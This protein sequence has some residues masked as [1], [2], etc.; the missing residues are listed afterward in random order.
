MGRAP[1]K[2]TRLE[3]EV[4]IFHETEILSERPAST[5]PLAIRQAA[6]ERAPAQ[7]DAKSKLIAEYLS[8]FQLV[9]KGGLYIDGFAA[10]QKR[11]RLDSWTARRVLEITLNRPGFTG[12]PNPPRIANHG[13][14]DHQEAVLARVS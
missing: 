9:T 12:G 1:R 8:R 2:T 10:P 3:G 7:T 11:D 5:H 14:Q 4:P 13:P 6:A